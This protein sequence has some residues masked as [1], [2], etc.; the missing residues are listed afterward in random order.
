MLP[1]AFTTR[2]SLATVLPS[3]L[4]AL[5]GEGNALDLP[6][7]EHV[8]VIVVDGLGAAALRAR[9]GH[10]R[11]MAPLLGKAT[12]IDAGFPTTT[13][14]ALTTLTTGTTPGE[15]GMVGYRVRDAAGRLT[16]QLN[17]WDDRMD[18]AT[19]QRSRT[20][21]QTAAA[22][23]VTTRA[24]GLAKYADSGF[25]AA[26]LRGAE[27]LGGRTMAD[28]FAIGAEVAATSG[29]GLT[30]LYVAELDQLAHARGWESPEWTTALETLDALVAGFARGLG[31][32]RAALLT[33]DHGVVDVPES[34]HVLFDTAPELLEG[35]ADIAGEPR[36]LHL[37]TR[38]GAAEAVAARWQEAEGE[39]AWVATREQAVAA[40]WF[41]QGVAPEVAPR[42][43]DVLVAARKRIAY[44]DS[45]D[46][47][48]TGRN[49]VGQHGSLTPEET[50]VPLLRF[51]AAA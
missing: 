6:P 17:G 36:L 42:I 11:T 2:A 37:Y 32:G 46:P 28:R 45:R 10:A 39:R 1:A 15:H 14:A 30:Y 4:A 20:V 33:A 8:V 16:N 47:Q 29:P 27:F 31:P 51:G 3:S 50:R 40:G 24:I 21:F 18:P 44:Y 9:A 35:V 34:G 22:E 41:G 43:G 23:G 19:W 5:R 49:M 13:A 48:R 7:L 38:E 12:T 25:T 26:V